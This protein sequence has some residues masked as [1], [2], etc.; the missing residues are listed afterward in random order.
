MWD[1]WWTKWHW[2]GFFPKYFDLPLSIYFIPLVL[3]YTEKQK[4]KLIIIIT[5]LHIR[6][7]AA[8]RL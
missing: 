8:V 4:Q 2:D 3:H 6:F 5:G 1:L 7:K